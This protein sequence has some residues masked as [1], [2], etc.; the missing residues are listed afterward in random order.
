MVNNDGSSVILMEDFSF[1][2]RTPLKIKKISHIKYR[3]NE[4][5]AA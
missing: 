1:K 3:E 2:E 4:I 5:R